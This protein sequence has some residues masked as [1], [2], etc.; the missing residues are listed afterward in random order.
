MTAKVH[1]L[2]SSKTTAEIRDANAAQKNLDA[3]QKDALWQYF[4]AAMSETGGPFDL[5]AR[6]VVAGLI[7]D[8]HHSSTDGF[9]LGHAAVGYSSTEKV[10][11]GIFG[12]HL[13]YS[14]P[15]FLEE[16]TGCMTDSR[17][18][19]QRVSNELGE[20]NAI[21]EACAIGQADF[22]TEV[23]R[24]LGVSRGPGRLMREYLS[25]WTKHFLPKAPYCGHA[26]TEGAL[27]DDF[28]PNLARWTLKDAVMFR[29]L[30]H[31][32]LPTDPP[33]T[34]QELLW[35]PLARVDYGGEEKLT[36]RLCITCSSS[37]VGVTIDG[38]VEKKP[39]VAEP[40]QEVYH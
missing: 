19:G 18:P 4:R 11:L 2:R 10:S 3:Q 1:I 7:L 5:S 31:V 36:A 22:L 23:G 34:P 17:A 29:T 28:M 38:R 35:Q 8:S 27:V 33:S 9:V 12:S 37:I 30:P 26:K 24:A 21:W 32:R 20:R 15:R 25:D 16:V 39:S 40:T 14:W 13:T 6:P